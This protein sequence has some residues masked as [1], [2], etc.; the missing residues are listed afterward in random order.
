[1]HAERPA[2]A[3]HRIHGGHP[4][5]GLDVG[6]HP[7][8][9]ARALRQLGEREPAFQTL[10]ANDCRQRWTNR[11]KRGARNWTVGN[12]ERQTVFLLFSK[13]DADNFCKFTMTKYF[14]KLYSGKFSLRFLVG[15]H[16][17]RVRD[18]F[19]QINSNG[20]RDPQHGIQGGIS[21]I[22]FNKADDGMRQTRA[23][24]HDVH[25]KPALFTRFPQKPNY[26]GNSGFS[27]AV[28]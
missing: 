9:K 2:D 7:A 19:A 27:N 28:F 24:R 21:Q 1:L 23:L 17:G 11:V 6:E 26:I 18:G 5:A 22:V 14:N 8:G 16:F 25:G 4:L 15:C 12:G 20:F 10:L 13:T 3:G